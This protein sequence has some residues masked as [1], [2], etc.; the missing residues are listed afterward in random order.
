MQRAP[1]LIAAAIFLAAV[2]AAIHLA[3]GPGPFTPGSGVV[4]GIGFL[5][6][7]V[8]SVAGLLVSRGRW[9]RR[10]A[11]GTTVAIVAGAALTAPWSV[12]SIAAVGLGGAA[13]VGL[14]GRW[15]DGWIRR[16]PT[17]DGPGVRVMLLVL[18][19]IGLVPLVAL[20]APRT[21]SP[22]HGVL[23]A[24]GIFYGWAYSRAEVWAMW[25]IRTTLPLLAV[26]ALVGSPA[27][28]VVLLTIA[29][30]GL[31]ALA[32]TREARLAVE[33]LM[34]RLPGPRALGEKGGG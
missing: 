8:I 21:I 20:A 5:L 34:D 13:F 26:P 18:G 33:P 10:F 32:W 25:A 12:A 4:L 3:G 6:Y 27:P 23:G 16:L 29:V 2:A 22:G 15:L 1:H 19:L 9:A 24:A 17:P 11:S 7:G 31:T 14:T 30:V 28:G